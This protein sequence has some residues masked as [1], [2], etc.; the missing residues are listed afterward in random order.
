[1]LSQGIHPGATDVCVPIFKSG[2]QTC[3]GNYRP[4]SLSLF[5]KILEK[6]MYRRL[7]SYIEKKNI[8]FQNQFGF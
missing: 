7:V 1:M 2:D 4:I 8:V 6:L 5:N 3:L